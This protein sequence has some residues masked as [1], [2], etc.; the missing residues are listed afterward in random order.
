MRYR[1][2]EN[3]QE[4]VLIDSRQLAVEVFNQHGNG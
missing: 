3:L 2:I 4:Y 1:S